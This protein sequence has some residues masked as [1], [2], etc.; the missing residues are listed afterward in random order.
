MIGIRTKL[1]SERRG[2]GV[3]IVLTAS[4][5][6][7]SDFNLHPFLAFTGGFP[8]KIVPTEILRKRW[9]PPTPDNGDGSALFAPY[10]LRKIEWILIKEF[11][12]ANVIV[13]HPNNLEKFVGPKTKVVGISTMDPLG[14]G[15]VSRTYTPLVGFGG[16]PLAA[17]EFKEMITNPSLKNYKPKILVG[18]SGAWQIERAKMREE[19]GIDT[20]VMGEGERTAVEIFKRAMTD[21]K[22]PAVVDT[23]H[24]SPEEI[25]T[26]VH[27]SLYGTVEI[28]RGC[29]RGCQFCSP[30]MRHRV[31]FPLEHI[32]KEVTLNANAG[33][34]MIILQTEDVFLYK[35]KE[36]FM[37]NREAI[38]ELIQSVANVPGVEYIQIA[39]ASLAPVVVDPKMIEEIAPILLEK[40]R[41]RHLGKNP[42]VSVEIGIETGSVRLMAKYMKRKMLPYKPEDWQDVVTQS[43]GIMNDNKMYPLATL[44]TGLPDENEEDIIA[45]MEL[46]DKLKSA[47]IFYVPLLFTSEEDCLLRSARQAELPHL[48]ELQWE[49]IATC[50]EHNV[51]VWTSPLG[52]SEIMVGSLL[53]YLLYYRWKHGKKFFRL[54]TK[55][56]GWENFFV[57][58]KIDRKCDPKYCKNSATTRYKR[59]LKQREG[60]KW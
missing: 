46:I 2:G 5:I 48:T 49:F 29:G 12:A 15:F 17:V 56:S 59:W 30:T 54:I 28:M 45:T 40:A 20:V 23:E 33:S 27:P 34:K 53:A 8:S 47:K 37:P 57:G 60:G 55:F 25:P 7:M 19:L 16:E 4:A 43:I 14:M 58:R 31:S 50:W 36:K 21:K 35:T 41:D 22:L 26:I 13:T 52:K 10:G 39:H 24:P 1:K 32:I 6:E 18:G 42:F 3:P 38:V 11:G 9:Y 51:N 44:I